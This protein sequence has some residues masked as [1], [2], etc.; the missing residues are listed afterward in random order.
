MFAPWNLLWVAALFVAMT[1]IPDRTPLLQ[2]IAET[3]RR[4]AQSRKVNSRTVNAIGCSG[5]KI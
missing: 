5:K 1:D 2:R 4:I 3:V